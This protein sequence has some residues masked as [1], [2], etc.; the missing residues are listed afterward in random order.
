MADLFGNKCQKQ[1]IYIY[2]DDSG[3]RYSETFLLWVRKCDCLTADEFKN[4]ISLLEKMQGDMFVQGKSLWPP[5]YAEFV[6]LAKSTSK[7][8]SHRLFISDIPMSWDDKKR[9]QEVG[10]KYLDYILNMLD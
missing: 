10:R 3:D 8:R 9:S 4:G 5:S 2:D 1:G 6:R 7:H